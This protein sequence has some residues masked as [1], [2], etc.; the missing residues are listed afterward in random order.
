[1]PELK[2]TRVT[3]LA[4]AFTLPRVTVRLPA[5]LAW[6]QHLSKKEQAE[7]SRQ[8]LEAVLAACA[9]G[10]WD[11][12]T[13]LLDDCQATAEVLADPELTAILTE[14]IANQE[15]IPWGEVRTR[16]LGQRPSTEV[17]VDATPGGMSFEIPEAHIPDF[18]VI[19]ARSLST[20]Q[21][22]LSF[23]E[24]G[25]YTELTY[26]TAALGDSLRDVADHLADPS[27]IVEFNNA[28]L[29]TGGGGCFSLAAALSPE[30]KAAIGNAVLQ[31]F[32]VALYLQREPFS[33]ILRDG[34]VEV[35]T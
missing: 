20:Q 22:R 23:K 21:I 32:G 18:L 12:V 24:N 11:E 25:R 2:E 14:P 29:Y 6:L 8:L 30:K 28:T 10:T 9:Q 31:A 19:L 1:M 17:Y 16:L 35:Y 33:V 27:L 4:E 26:A 34:K 15:L 7:F 13:Q 5:S 3:Y